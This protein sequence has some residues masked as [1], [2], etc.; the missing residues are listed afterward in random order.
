LDTGD[1]AM[2]CLFYM[3]GYKH[4]YRGYDCKIRGI[5]YYDRELE[6]MLIDALPAEVSALRLGG[7]PE[8]AA[9]KIKALA[10]AARKENGNQH[11]TDEQ[12]LP[13]T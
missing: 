5:P 13:A 11:D 8:L 4:G 1:V 10:L 12:E 7:D 2:M 9:E 6:K 3:L